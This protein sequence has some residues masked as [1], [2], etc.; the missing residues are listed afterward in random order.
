MGDAQERD[1][2]RT[3][4]CRGVGCVRRRPADLRLGDRNGVLVNDQQCHFTPDSW[5]NYAVIG[6]RGRIES[7]GDRAGGEI[8]LWNERVGF[9]ECGSAVPEREHRRRPRR[10]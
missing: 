3:D 10:R 5:R 7:R 1:G 4:H 6:T 2:A 9:S 8:R